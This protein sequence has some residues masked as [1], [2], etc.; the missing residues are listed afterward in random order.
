MLFES[1]TVKFIF[2]YIMILAFLGCFENSMFDL[3]LADHEN[4]KSMIEWIFIIL[5]LSEVYLSIWLLWK[6]AKVSD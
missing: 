4:F 5:M 1:H 3:F 2:V 6:G